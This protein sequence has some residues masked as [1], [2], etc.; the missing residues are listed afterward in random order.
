[1]STAN[2]WESALA[3]MQRQGETAAI[4][5]R[6]E[7]AER[8]Y[9]DRREFLESRRREN[10]ESRESLNNIVNS[11]YRIARENRGTVPKELVPSFEKDLNAVYRKLGNKFQVSLKGLGIDERDG[12][13]VTNGELIGGTGETVSQGEIDRISAPDMLKRF[14]HSGVSRDIQLDLLKRLRREYT[15]DQMRKLGFG[16]MIDDA[17]S[18]EG[19]GAGAKQVRGT[20]VFKGADTRPHGVHFF[21]S[22]GNGGLSSSDWTP[23]GG[24]TRRDWGTRDPNYKGRW[25]V[26]VNGPDG[27]VYENDKTG[28]EITVKP[29]ENLRDVLAKSEKSEGKPGQASG[30]GVE[31]AKINSASREK[32]AGMTTSS[33]ERIVEGNNKTRKEIAG[34]Q[35]SSREKIAEAANSLKEL[36][37]DVSAALKERGYDLQ[38]ARDAETARHNKAGEGIAG[39]RQREQERHNKEQERLRGKS[40]EERKRHNRAGEATAER[41]ADTQERRVEDQYELGDRK[42]THNKNRLEQDKAKSGRAADQRDAEL[43]ERKRQFDEREKRLSKPKDQGGTGEDS[44]KAVSAMKG[45]LELARTSGMS[46]ED[47]ADLES[48]TN[49]RIKGM[50]GMGGETSGDGGAKGK[51]KYTDLKP[52]Q[53]FTMT[54]KDGKKRR[55]VKTEKGYKFID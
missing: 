20:A 3:D 40:V 21:A 49:E 9:Q 54:D 32:I 30:A 46:D 28:E 34:A 2:E 41:R 33:R 39:S 35:I 45:M 29:G 6:T 18:V 38:E 47:L 13:F 11:A 43:A 5:R 48:W 19:A 7:A 27:K 37:I 1:M 52:G 51:V 44:R 22:D 10:A 4:A 42:Q 53:K 50:A 25:K 17:W 55:C 15:T 36:G 26:R 14:R 16:D 24:E 8:D 12:S 31:I 23:E